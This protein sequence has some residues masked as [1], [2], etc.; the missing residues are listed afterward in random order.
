MIK[1]DLLAALKDINIKLKDVDE[2]DV[3]F[4]VSFFEAL[5][6]QVRKDNQ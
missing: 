5:I 6:Q 3:D 1:E 2:D 4:L